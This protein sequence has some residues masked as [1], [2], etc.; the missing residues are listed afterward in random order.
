MSYSLIAFFV[1]LSIALSAY[2]LW[3]MPISTASLLEKMKKRELKPGEMKMGTPL[4]N[5]PDSGNAKLAGRFSKLV[6]IFKPKNM[7]QMD[8]DEVHSKILIAGNPFN[9]SDEA[10]Q[11]GLQITFAA[12][13]AICGLL[14]SLVFNLVPIAGGAVGAGLGYALPSLVL[15]Q[16]AGKR[17]RSMKKMLPE[18][19][20]L[21]SVSM[22]AG[23]N[24][25]PALA[26]V[27]E[28]MPDSIV[29]DEFQIVSG[30]I[31]SGMKV[32]DALSR[33]NSRFDSQELSAFVKA[34]KLSQSTGSDIVDILSKMSVYARES[35]ESDITEKAAKL[36]GKIMM[37]MIPFEVPAFTLMFLITPIYQMTS[38][39]GF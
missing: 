17:S 27:S 15:K 28:S 23:L 24:F 25:I 18:A 35:Y 9:V 7:T 39:G 22:K 3:G 2:A 1:F 29:K 5:N 8:R 10:E 6:N 26:A 16:E 38:G 4:Q 33:L 20:D 37:I 36:E 14:I 30:N 32:N 34:V 21:L 31:G 13:F 19:L 12:I 11:K